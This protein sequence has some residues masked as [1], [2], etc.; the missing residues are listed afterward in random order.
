MTDKAETFTAIERAIVGWF[1][2]SGHAVLHEESEWLLVGRPAKM[3]E[4]SITALACAIHQALEKPN[5][6]RR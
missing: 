1:E 2:A 4:M 3:Q 6:E 5:E